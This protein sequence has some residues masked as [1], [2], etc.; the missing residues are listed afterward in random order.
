MATFKLSSAASLNL[1]QSQNG[2]LGNGLSASYPLKHFFAAY[3]PSKDKNPCICMIGI[4]KQ[5]FR[6][7]LNAT[8]I[9][10]G[11]LDGLFIVA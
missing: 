1:G 2:V 6:T 10:K 9:A 11:C 7:Y 3:E 4:D 5:Y 8:L